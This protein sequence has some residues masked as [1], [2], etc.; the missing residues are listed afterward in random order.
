[1]MIL[2]VLEYTGEGRFKLTR[3]VFDYRVKMVSP[4]TLAFVVR[5][6]PSRSRFAR[7]WRFSSSVY[8][9]DVLGPDLG[10]VCIL[11]GAIDD[12]VNVAVDI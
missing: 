6:S 12:V 11:C 5:G 4:R 2:E 3:S 7:S 10:G 9:R 1:M 8:R